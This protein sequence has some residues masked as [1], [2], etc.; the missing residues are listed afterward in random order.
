MDTLEKINDRFE[1]PHSIDLS[2]FLAQSLREIRSNVY[3]LFG[4]LVHAGSVSGGHYYAFLRTSL[5][6]QWFEF[7]DT[8]VTRVTEEVAVSG[9]FGGSILQASP[10]GYQYSTGNRPDSAYVLIYVRR[11]DAPGIFEPIPDSAVPDHLRGFIQQEDEAE[12]TQTSEVIEF[13]CYSE[14]SIRLNVLSHKTGFMNESDRRLLLL[15]HSATYADLYE[16][17][18]TTF[19]R[20]TQQF[21]LWTLVQA[22]RVWLAPSD[23]PVASLYYRSLFFQKVDT[24]DVPRP[25]TAT[26]FFEFLVPTADA[27]IQYLG[28]DTISVHSTLKSLFP[29]VNQRIGFSPDFALAVSNVS[30]SV[31]NIDPGLTLEQAQISDGCVL[32]FEV[33]PRVPFPPSTLK[34]RPALATVAVPPPD[35]TLPLFTYASVFGVTSELTLFKYFTGVIDQAHVLFYRYETP[36]SPLCRLQ[37]P[38]FITIPTLT[39]FIVRALSLDVD[40]ENDS[41]LLFKKEN[42]QELPVKQWLQPQYFTVVK[43]AIPTAVQLQKLFFHVAKG[44]PPSELD[45]LRWYCARISHDGVNLSN[46]LPGKLLPPTALVGDLIPESLANVDRGLL[47]VS[48][49]SHARLGPVIELDT[50]LSATWADIRIDILPKD[51]RSIDPA[52]EKIVAVSFAYANASARAECFGDPFWFRVASGETAQALRARLEAALRV[53][54]FGKY[55]LM[56][57]RD[58]TPVRRTAFL[59]PDAIVWE[60]AEELSLLLIDRTQ[61]AVR[62]REEVL[63]IYN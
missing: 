2:P 54:D 58:S 50:P 32:A 60:N 56:I 26:I 21:H 28:S 1:F 13:S 46:E 48:A 55:E 7:N 33:P 36:E 44:V 5:D 42:A 34:I 24:N 45:K 25:D 31:V 15:P 39:K 22:P 18:A 29:K 27:P 38:T 30:T 10:T 53:E 9:N 23:S 20:S 37:F 6:P 63:K 43:Y 11:D 8:S 12:Q 17:A 51:Q 62:A 41:L 49:V 4:V 19:N 52:K 14:K 57:G 16:A 59:K 35:P 3:D 61:K 40:L 47:R